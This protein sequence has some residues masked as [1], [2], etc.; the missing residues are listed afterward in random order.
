MGISIMMRAGL[1][2]A[3]LVVL[4]L[5]VSGLPM[6]EDTLNLAQEASSPLD[7]KTLTKEVVADNKLDKRNL[8]VEAIQQRNSVRV[9]KRKA[10]E[11]DLDTKEAA[12]R[13]KETV[14]VQTVKAK[15][16]DAYNKSVQAAKLSKIKE[17]KV[18]VDKRRAG[19]KQ[20]AKQETLDKIDALKAAGRQEKAAINTWKMQRVLARDHEMQTIT[21]AANS[22]RDVATKDAQDEA[23]RTKEGAI[24]QNSVDLTKANRAVATQKAKA[25]KIKANVLRGIRTFSQPQ[26]LLDTTS[27]KDRAAEAAKEHDLSKLKVQQ[28]VASAG[29]SEAREVQAANA[30][31][32][33][34]EIA[35]QQKRTNAVAAAENL[36]A[37]K[38]KNANTIFAQAKATALATE[39]SL[40]AKAT[41]AKQKENAEALK[42]RQD[43]ESKARQ[44]LNGEIAQAEARAKS[45]LNTAKATYTEGL[46]KNQEE[47]QRAKQAAETEEAAAIKRA[48][49][50]NKKRQM[51][52]AKAKAAEYEKLAAG[53]AV[54]SE[55]LLQESAEP[56]TATASMSSAELSSVQEEERRA[57]AKAANDMIFDSTKNTDDV[58]QAKKEAEVSKAETDALNQAEEAA[59]KAKAAA[60]E[61][62]LKRNQE[63][64]DTW[65]NAV[66]L[67]NKRFRTAK[68]EIGQEAGA[69]KVKATEAKDSAYRQ[70]TAKWEKAKSQARKIELEKFRQLEEVEA[71]KITKH[72]QVLTAAEKAIEADHAQKIAALAQKRKEEYAAANQKNEQAKAKVLKLKAKKMDQ[73]S[74]AQAK[75]DQQDEKII[76]A[77]NSIEQRIARLENPTA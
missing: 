22:A 56:Q 9:M 32:T 13:R 39:A 31:Q 54:G 49:L 38:A 37:Q 25:A 29:A 77:Q 10:L 45:K 67:A 21:R 51:K 36:A 18:A 55:F 48:T 68:E 63:A 40:K 66:Q 52:A 58:I 7:S 42:T 17:D 69:A 4:T 72:K 57:D 14:K 75:A 12:T 35:A 73:M 1:V 33:Q 47:L 76:P 62:E 60:T 3:M 64:D 23:A 65:L 50:A 16:A 11:G 30:A 27:D 43:G 44:E 34:K 20:S 2:A 24:R 59:R 28:D 5:S 61:Q 6:R 70:A 15:A 26:V 46:K 19:A 53:G 71:Q 8:Q 74:A 41:Q